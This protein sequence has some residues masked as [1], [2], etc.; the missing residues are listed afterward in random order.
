MKEDLLKQYNQNLNLNNL[1]NGQ[2]DCGEEIED[3]KKRILVVDDSA[4]VLRNIKAMLEPKYRVFVATSGEQ[5]LK[6]I[7]EKKP[8]LILLDYEMPEMNGKETFEKIKADEMSKDIPV[9]FLTGVDDKEHIFAVLQLNPAG[10]FLKPPTR[11]KLLDAIEKA[12]SI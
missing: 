1:E 5:A 9:I 4:L 12:L 3:G 8:N 6:F 10:Y 2:S 7:P 11:S